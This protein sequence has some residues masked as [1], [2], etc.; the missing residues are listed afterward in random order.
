MSCALY[1]PV[2]SGSLLLHVEVVTQ[3]LESAAGEMQS[4]GENHRQ[5]R[6][7]GE[8]GGTVCVGR[9]ILNRMLTWSVLSGENETLIH[10]NT[11]M[12]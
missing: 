12:L 11:I 3:V 8:E 10:R 9:D 6:G 7:G 1:G 4:A 5:R 2:L